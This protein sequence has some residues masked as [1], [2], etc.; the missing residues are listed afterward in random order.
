MK[1]SSMVSGFLSVFVFLIGLGP[2]LFLSQ[3]TFWSTDDYCRVNSS[4][5]NFTENFLTWYSTHNGRYTNAMLSLLPVYDYPF[6]QISSGIAIV[7]FLVSIFLLIRSLSHHYYFSLTLPHHLLITSLVSLII[8]NHLPSVADF[9]YWYA[10]ITS[11]LI[12][13]SILILLVILLITRKLRNRN[14]QLLAGLII[15]IGNGNNEII[16]VII[17]FLLL[18]LFF[19]KFFNKKKIYL[20]LL[21]LI[22]TSWATSLIVFLSPGSVQRRKLYPEGGELLNS[23]KY[24]IFHSSRIAI[25]YLLHPSFLL[26]TLGLS[27]LLLF[28]RKPFQRK[29]HNYIS[30]FLLLVLSFAVFTIPFFV[31]IYAQGYFLD[32]TRTNNFIFVLFYLLAILNIFAFSF[33]LKEKVLRRQITVAY[34]L[35]I[36]LLLSSF[37]LSGSNFKQVITDIRGGK[38]EL[39]LQ[40]QQKRLKKIKSSTGV[41][42]LD[43]IKGPKTLWREEIPRAPETWQHKC[44]KEMIRNKY[45]KNVKSVRMEF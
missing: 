30:P 41:V 28:H 8:I 1:K 38:A 2:F 16:M 34:P 9:F 36:V 19:W 7:V 43:T 12:S 13:L 27:F 4:W 37:I 21:F 32:L 6:Y 10:G 33:Y 17:N 31:L 18:S 40:R 42:K 29:D 3:Y 24:G 25:D 11:Y 26:F 22:A 35:S 20:S 14:T 23:V 45:N 5:A 15:I 39:Y 44:F